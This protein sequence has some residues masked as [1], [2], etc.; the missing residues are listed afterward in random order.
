MGRALLVIAIVATTLHHADAQSGGTPGQ[1]GGPPGGS[2]A[3]GFGE[4]PHTPP[5]SPPSPPSQCQQLLTLRDELQK[6]GAAITAANDKKADV[7][8]ACRLFRTYIATEGKMLR[9]LET[10]GA[11]C[12]VSA[13]VVRRSGAAT[14]RRSR[15]ANRFAIGCRHSPCIT[16]R[17]H[18]AKITPAK[19]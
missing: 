18:S 2:P 7:R 16:I 3:E 17:L 8:I 1:P 14:P 10:N 15:S 13:E 19:G 4:A 11:S 9:A 12:G 6:H 5:T